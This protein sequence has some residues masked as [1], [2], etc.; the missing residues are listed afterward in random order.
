[1]TQVE[2]LTILQELERDRQRLNAA[3]TELYR[4]TLDFRGGV[5]QDGVLH[6]GVAD[7]FQQCLDTELIELEERYLRLEQKLPATDIRTARVNKIVREKYPELWTRYVALEA[8]E[9]SLRQ[10][11]SGRKSAIGAAQSILRGERI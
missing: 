1:M 5:D 2:E 3:T 7:E 8:Q 11:I 10:V 4:V 6:R 9:R